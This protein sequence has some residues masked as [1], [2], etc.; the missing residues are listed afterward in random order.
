MTSVSRTTQ[1]SVTCRQDVPEFGP[2]LPEPS[3]FKKDECF[4]EWLYC[5][6]INAETA[7]CK[8]EQF[9]K[10]QYR[11]RYVFFFARSAFRRLRHV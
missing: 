11:T 3:I 1:V 5:K 10:L 7:C 6:L 9:A 4:R 8:S 2:P